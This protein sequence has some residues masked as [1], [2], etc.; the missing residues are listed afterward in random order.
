MEEWLTQK[1]EENRPHLRAAAYRML[2]P[3]HRRALRPCALAPS[4]RAPLYGRSQR[5]RK[6]C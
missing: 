1:F 3:Q 5:A 4:A 6:G 2:E